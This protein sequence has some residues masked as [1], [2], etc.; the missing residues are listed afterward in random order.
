M[1]QQRKHLK[2]SILLFSFFFSLKNN[3]GGDR[4]N[5]KILLAFTSFLIIAMMATPL[6]LALSWEPKNNS[7]FQS[8]DVTATLLGGTNQEQR[9]VPSIPLAG[10]KL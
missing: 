1:K 5:K 9:F 7:K 4:V 6:A 8:F 10:K 2:N 3:K